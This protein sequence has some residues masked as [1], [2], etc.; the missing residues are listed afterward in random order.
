M[1][2]LEN[3]EIISYKLGLEEE[4]ISLL[5]LAFEHWPDR[6]LLCSKVEHWRWKYLDNPVTKSNIIIAKNSE[7]L[8]GC[9]HGY[10]LNVKVGHKTL[11]CAQGTD[12]AV[13]PDYQGKGIYSKMAQ[14]K[15]VVYKRNC[16]NISYWISETP[17]FIASAKRKRRPTLPFPLKNMLWV[18][19]IRLHLMQTNTDRKI[20]KMVGY[21][22]LKA[23]IFL[24]TF[25]SGNVWKS[26]PFKIVGIDK[27]DDSINVFWEKVKPHYNF[28]VERPCSY[29]NYRYCD[30]RAGN[31]RVVVA[32]DDGGILGYLVLMVNRVREYPSGNILDVLCLP[33][34]LDV[35]DALVKDAVM[36]FEG[37]DVNVIRAWALEGHPYLEILE[38]NGF[39][40][41]ISEPP[42]LFFNLRDVGDEWDVVQKSVVD[43]IHLQ[44]GDTE[45]M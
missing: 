18:K 36:F 14:L 31:Y 11:L 5:E 35:V 23:F 6:D 28:I 44:M 30:D 15:G 9:D 37:E 21:Y 3:L 34:R 43:K 40:A 33:G 42:A 24:R 12:T 20:W 10:F 26:T 1:S 19:N 22:V 38:N 13:H 32:E 7:L 25:F 45:W 41:S 8:L 29:L 27:F 4:I 39:L 16:I 17:I 2:A